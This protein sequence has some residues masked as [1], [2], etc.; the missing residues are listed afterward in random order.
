MGIEGEEPFNKCPTNSLSEDVV[1]CR[2]RRTEQPAN[3]V[4][5]CTFL[6]QKVRRGH[7]SLA[8][9]IVLGSR[10]YRGFRLVTDPLER[11][12]AIEDNPGLRLV[13]DNNIGGD[14]PEPAA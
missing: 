6:D 11:L 4:P 10:G 8:R 13:G 14:E 2:V 12:Q 7:I 1:V 9:S 5:M 3:V